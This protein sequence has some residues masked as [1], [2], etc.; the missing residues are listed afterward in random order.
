MYGVAAL[1][2]RND[3]YVRPATAAQ[4]LACLRWAS[5]LLALA[6]SWSRER[7][8]LNRRVSGAS[9]V[10]GYFR[11]DH[12]EATS[13]RGGQKWPKNTHKFETHLSRR[14]RVAYYAAAPRRLQ[15]RALFLAVE[16]RLVVVPM[17]LGPVRL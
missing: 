3:V 11:S 2:A 8:Q 6:N 9:G 12:C 4:S 14:A 5:V 10:T 17:Q 16:A 1:V 15:A 13:R 7:D